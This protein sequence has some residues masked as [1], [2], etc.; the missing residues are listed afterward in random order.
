MSEDLSE[1]L[2]T[3]A[4]K[5]ETFATSMRG[6]KSRVW[7]EKAAEQEQKAKDARDAATAIRSLTGER[8]T[9]KRAAEKYSKQILTMSDAYEALDDKAAA[10]T[11][12]VGELEA[13]R[14]DRTRKIQSLWALNDGLKAEID[15]L[16]GVIPVEQLTAE[17]K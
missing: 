3:W 10:L 4:S 5:L 2:E 1:R 12:R 16:R 11:A 6:S 13:E 17:T 9:Y 7:I 14:E 15:R 8:D